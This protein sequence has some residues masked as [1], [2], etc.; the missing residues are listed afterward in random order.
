ME[1]NFL[2]Q[3]PCISSWLGVF[4]FDIFLRVVLS[5]SVRISA[6]GPSS[7]PSRSLVILF[8]HSAFSL[9]FW[10]P[11]FSPE[12][13]GFFCIRLLVCFVDRIFFHC[14]GMS[15]FACVV[16]PFVDIS[17]IFLLSQVLS[18]LFPQVIL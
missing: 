6:F 4:Q 8:I 2:N 12:S 18:G 1:V 13:L 7:N 10:L 15:C 17:L 5:K 9:C 11:Y 14:F 16:L 3:N